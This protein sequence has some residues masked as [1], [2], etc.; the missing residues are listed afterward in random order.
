MLTK[1]SDVKE[2]SRVMINKGVIVRNFSNN[3]CEVMHPSGEVAYFDRA[4]LKWTLT[5]EK[6]LRR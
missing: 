3:D 4:N 5:N 2:T 6:G 1:D